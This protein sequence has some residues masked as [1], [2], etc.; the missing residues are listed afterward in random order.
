[1]HR[2][3]AEALEDLC[4]GKPGARVTEL[5]RHWAAA[6]A[7]ADTNKALDYSMLAGEQALENLAPDEAVPWLTQALD[8]LQRSSEPDPAQRCELTIRLG[9]A[10]RQAGQAEYRETLLRA[11]AQAD[12]LQ[13]TDR[14]ARAALANSRGFASAFGAVDEERLAVLEK[15]IEGDC[16]SNPA[17]CAELLA[18]EAMELQFDSD[19]VRRRALADE[20]LA[21]AR[22]AGEPRV[23]PYVLRDH[24]HAT[25][26]ADTL[27]TRRET[28]AEMLDLAH[29]LNDPL[30]RSWALD[31]SV[32]VAAE[33]GDLMRAQDVSSALLA[34]AEEVGQPRLRWHASYYAA[35]LAQLTGT[36][37]ESER[38][39]EA[40][41]RLGEQ[42]REPDTV[43][44]YFA[45]LGTVRVEQGRTR[46]IVDML[47]QATIANPGIQAFEAGYAAA[48]C[49]IGGAAQAGA[50]L[51]RAAARR[52]A[53]VPLNQVYSTT[54]ALWSRTAADVGAARAASVLY[55]LLEPLREGMVW[56]GAT[57][58]GSVESYLG[59]LAAAM[60]AHDR[61]QQ[62]FATATVVHEQQGVR[63][64]EA[65]N[66][67]FQA[68]SL[69][70]SG[71]PDEGRA[72]A[73]RAI[74]LAR[75]S[76]FNASVR[77]AEALL[78]PAATP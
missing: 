57:G 17:R 75:E 28:A 1:M 34:L 35:G 18:L 70:A 54:L 8:L 78:E 30:A 58:Y 69:I 71:A 37:E 68:G 14:M 16:A 50:R 31:R 52:F 59:M 66:L 38:L 64:F 74:S 56:N 48:L 42:A 3:V 23:L 62:H 12:E 67:C 26:S 60:G 21:L 72:A 51:D 15:A 65:R 40:A 43:V 41:S 5:A 53:D 61:A 27:A 39:V 29:S 19:H 2:R 13:D 47:E 73:M 6:T 22:E 11:A 4:G 49:D 45:Q 25:W 77:R 24:F 33:S 10:Q 36:L 32:Q 76:G 7:L 44:I 63:G 20:A 9:E 46:E 55:D